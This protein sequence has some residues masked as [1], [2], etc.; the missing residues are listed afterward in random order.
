MTKQEE[1]VSLLGYIDEV[2]GGQRGLD[3]YLGLPYRTIYRY[4]NK[5]PSQ[6]L[7]H[8]VKLRESIDLNLLSKLVQ[9]RESDLLATK[10]DD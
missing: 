4:Y 1:E 3:R 5:T 10:S 6:L 9:R 2:H 7:M 8:H